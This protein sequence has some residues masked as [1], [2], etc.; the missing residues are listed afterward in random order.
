MFLCLMLF[1]SADFEVSAEELGVFS[2]HGVA[3]QK[4]DSRFVLTS[5]MDHSVCLIS[6]DGKVLK[7]YAVAGQGPNELYHPLVLGASLD[8]ILVRTGRFSVV[9]FDHNLELQE[10]MF[11]RMGKLLSEFS[12]NGFFKAPD[13]YIVAHRKKSPYLFEVFEFKQNSF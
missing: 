8:H 3:I 7:R 9:F 13:Q 4:I 2:N 1:I 6:P 5:M 10:S 11:I 12:G